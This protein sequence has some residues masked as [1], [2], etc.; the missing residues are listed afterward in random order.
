MSNELTSEMAWTTA[1]E[2]ERTVNEWL[3]DKPDIIKTLA[4]RF[5][6]GS[7]VRGLKEF[8]VPAPGE[9]A[10]VRSYFEDGSVGVFGYAMGAMPTD[11][12]CNADDLELVEVPETL[13]NWKED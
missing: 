8:L 6:P 13:R 12:S 1:D 3:R 10:K 9:V 11:T 5:P 4:K 7:L 2:A